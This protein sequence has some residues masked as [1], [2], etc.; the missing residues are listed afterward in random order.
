MTV[1]AAADDFRGRSTC[2]VTGRD[3]GSF[4]ADLRTLSSTSKGQA[5][6]RGGWGE[7]EYVRLALEPHGS[8]GHVGVRVVLRGREPG[9]DLRFEGGFV[10][11]P[12]PL[13]RFCEQILDAVGSER[14]GNYELPVVV[15]RRS[16]RLA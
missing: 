3:L 14:P 13:R 7:A 12:E 8:R 9:S 16:N 11:E 15:Q 5:L 4:L 2:I 1:D 10:A 6:L